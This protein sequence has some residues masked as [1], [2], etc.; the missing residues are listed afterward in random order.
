MGE[1]VVGSLSEFEFSD[2]GWPD[3]EVLGGG[4]EGEVLGSAGWAEVAVVGDCAV[5]V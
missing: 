3:I 2:A 1:V 5:V 4:C